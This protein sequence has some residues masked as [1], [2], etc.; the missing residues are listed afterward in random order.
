MGVGEGMKATKDQLVRP[1][2]IHLIRNG[3]NCNNEP[4]VMN[5]E[6]RVDEGSVYSCRFEH[7]TV[8]DQLIQIVVEHEVDVLVLAGAIFDSGNPSGEER[9]C[10]IG[11]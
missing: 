11:L 3:S 5:K 6:K 1:Y 8:F 7:I 10:S 2:G 4:G 9:N